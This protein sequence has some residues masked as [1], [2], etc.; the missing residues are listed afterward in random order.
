MRACFRSSKL[1]CLGIKVLKYLVWANCQG[2]L[3]PLACRVIKDIAICRIDVLSNSGSLGFSS[4]KNSLSLTT[5][6]YEIDG[7]MGARENCI[8]FNGL[9]TGRTKT[10]V[11][12]PLWEYMD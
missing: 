2:L 3:F 9:V 10:W 4:Q 5:G 1:P 7:T 6:F 12:Y 8:V 11:K